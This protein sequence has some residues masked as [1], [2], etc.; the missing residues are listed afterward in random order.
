MPTP[1]LLLSIIVCITVSFSCNSKKQIIDPEK[2]VSVIKDS[3]IINNSEVLGLASY[4][5]IFIENHRQ[6]FSVS[7]KKTTVVTGKKGLK[8]TVNPSALEKTDGRPVDGDIIIRIIELTNTDELFKSNAATVSDGRLLASGGS[9]FV[10]M[11]C[12]GEKLRIKKGRYLQMQFPQIKK[13]EM[14]LFYGQRNETGDMNWVSAETALSPEETD[15]EFTEQNTSRSYDYLPDLSSRYNIDTL[16]IYETLNEEVYYYEKKMTIKT[17]VDTINRHTTRIFIDT[18]YVWPKQPA[19]LPKGAKI[20]TNYLYRVYGPPKQFRLKTCH[21]L[22]AET[23]QM[24]NAKLRQQ[25]AVK[26]WQ[27]Q[28]LSNQL[29]KY[30]SPS[31]ITYLGWINCDR[32]Y[33]KNEQLNIIL[34]LPYTFNHSNIHY[35]LLFKSING[36]LS[37]RQAADSSGRLLINNIPQGIPAT[38]IAFT[39]NNGRIYQSKEDFIV[40]KDKPVKLDFTYITNDDMK[41]IFGKNVKM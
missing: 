10:G 12:N 28:K 38:L 39:K 20:D 41:N 16:R 34:D 11:E 9:Y 35:F 19:Y 4:N 1:R 15:L 26:N 17:L 29:Q 37:G 24:N 3:V 32:F 31:N 25:E 7:H 5:N 6:T 22:E 18:V 33:Q 8:I 13:E 23:E 21:A 2:N 40:N 27:P 30:Y 14:E 36:L